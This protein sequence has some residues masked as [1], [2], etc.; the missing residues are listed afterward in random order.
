MEKINYEPVKKTGVLSSSVY[1]DGNVIVLGGKTHIALIEGSEHKFAALEVTKATNKDGSPCLLQEQ[2]CE[3]GKFAV[4]AISSLKVKRVFNSE[5]LTS[6]RRLS[7]GMSISEILALEPGVEYRIIKKEDGYK[8]PF[9][10]NEGDPLVQNNSYR[11]EAVATEQPAEPAA[12]QP[13]KPTAKK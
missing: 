8:K 11:L 5:Q 2:D 4:L 13:A 7:S 3:D 9:G 1:E 12:K 6:N 10:W